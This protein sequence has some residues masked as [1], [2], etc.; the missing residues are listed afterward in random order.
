MSEFDLLD[1]A[2]RQVQTRR[3]LNDID[4]H[5]ELYESDDWSLSLKELSIHEAAEQ[6]ALDYL[7]DEAATVLPIADRDIDGRD[8]RDLCETVR[9][10]GHD[11][12]L[13]FHPPG[14]AGIPMVGVNPYT[15]EHD[16]LAMVVAPDALCDPLADKPEHVARHPVN[17]HVDVTPPWRVR[18]PRG[19]AVARRVETD[20]EWGE[21]RDR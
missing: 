9:R 18:D 16:D 3:V 7:T 11:G 13:V 4:R 20:F 17:S 15:W 12:L 5:A 8:L 1:R 6:A 14:I 2:R 10:A 21:S 19:V